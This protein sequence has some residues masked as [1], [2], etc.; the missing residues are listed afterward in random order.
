MPTVT[1][2]HLYCNKRQLKE[3]SLFYSKKPTKLRSSY[4]QVKDN[5]HEQ[6]LLHTKH[7][8]IDFI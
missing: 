4:R 5:N 8:S 3:Q 7:S 1:G 2:Q 6:I